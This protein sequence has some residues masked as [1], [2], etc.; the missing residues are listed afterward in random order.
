MK[1][2]ILT[3]HRG[4]NYGGYLQAWSLKK[5]IC[6]LGHE[7]E[8]INYKNYRHHDSEKVKFYVTMRLWR[9]YFKY[10]KARAFAKVL[11]EITSG[12]LML[13]AV[14]V[15]WIKYN[16]VVVGSDVVWDI[17]T[18]HYGSDPIYFGAIPGGDVAEWISYAPSCG[19][20]DPQ[21]KLSEDKCKGLSTF[22]TILVR[23]ENTQSM[24][25]RNLGKK[26]AIVVDPT[27]LTE[28]EV[29]EDARYRKELHL[30]GY[31]SINHNIANQIKNYA[32]RHD[33]KIV[34][35]GYR[36]KWADSVVLNLS[37]MDWLVRLK[38]AYC[39][40]TTTFHG[41]LY[42]LKFNKPFIVFANQWS[43]AK[44]R[45]PL[46]LTDTLDRMGE[47][48]TNVEQLLDSQIRTTHSNPYNESLAIREQSLALLTQA[49]RPSSND[50]EE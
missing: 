44:V 26:P 29:E 25:E 5:A 27:W 8:V 13:N 36:H 18:E 3:F 2:G 30:Y 21:A 35:Y 48:D 10:V 6:S 14:D 49:L 45:M 43:R 1:I 41:T 46:Q 28:P 47:K 24:V 38:S 33:L 42:S 32:K 4:P 40:I 39:V 17:E 19:S 50:I 7:A 15:N 23:D 31:G 34:S 12:K 37:P 9:T 16:K 22:K 20:A 11:P